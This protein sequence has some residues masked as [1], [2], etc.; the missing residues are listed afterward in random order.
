LQ[1]RASWKEVYVAS[2]P[3]F[4]SSAIWAMAFAVLA[5]LVP[6]AGQPAAGTNP[7]KPPAKVNWETVEL[8][9]FFGVLGLAM[10]T[11]AWC[12]ARLEYNWAALLVQRAF[13]GNQSGR[14][15]PRFSDFLAI[16]VRTLGVFV[17]SLL[18]VVLGYFAFGAAVMSWF[19]SS[20]GGL[21]VLS[22]LFV[23]LVSVVG[24]VVVF[25]LA[26][27]A[28]VPAR[29]YRDASLFKLTFNNVGVSSIARFKCDLKVSGFVWL[30][31]R[32]VLLT[33]ITLGF[34][35]PFA[36]VSEYAYKM[37]SVTLHVKGGVDQLAGQLGKE[38]GAIADAIADA[39][40]FDIV[41]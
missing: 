29:A 3:L 1:F 28:T 24:L 34:Y 35:R 19:K 6:D 36:M 17:A 18:V 10:V 21:G 8:G 15:K 12:F 39:A 33:V 31:I 23:V 14:W 16:W 41:N 27:F 32:N 30:R 25:L 5:L 13:V 9:K 26:L 40:G 37:N 2:W 7:L 22:I 4:V 38:E 11:S 20:F